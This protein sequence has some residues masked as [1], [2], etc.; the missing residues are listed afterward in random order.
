VCQRPAGY[1]FGRF[2]PADRIDRLQSER[3][4]YRSDPDGEGGAEP[5]DG[6]YVTV[7]VKRDG[8]WK[9]LTDVSVPTAGPGA[10]G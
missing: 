1:D 2:A 7:L 4:W 3:G 10:D 9:V 8:A 5:I 6:E